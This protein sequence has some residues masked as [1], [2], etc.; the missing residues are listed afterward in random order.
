MSALKTRKIHAPDEPPTIRGYVES[1]NVVIYN[2][3]SISASGSLDRHEIP[4]QTNNLT[5]YWRALS[6]KFPSQFRPFMQIGVQDIELL[7]NDGLGSKMGK[8]S[9]DNRLELRLLSSGI[10]SSRR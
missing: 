8:G 1:V 7:V 3:P 4:A 6:K 10:P 2:G 5:G 9:N